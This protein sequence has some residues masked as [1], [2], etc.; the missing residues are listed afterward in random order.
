MIAASL[1]I[2]V[3]LF[4]GCSIR[5]WFSRFRL[6]TLGPFVLTHTCILFGPWPSQAGSRKSHRRVVRSCPRLPNCM[7]GEFLGSKKPAEGRWGNLGTGNCPRR[8]RSHLFLGEA[9]LGGIRV[10]KGNSMQLKTLQLTQ[11]SDLNGIQW[12]ER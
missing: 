5:C 2:W 11:F 6:V 3:F 8:N 7:W 9:N 1:S 12:M 4:G 10:S